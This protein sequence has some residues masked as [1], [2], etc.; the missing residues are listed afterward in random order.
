MSLFSS[1]KGQCDVVEIMLIHFYESESKIRRLKPLQHITSYVTSHM[2]NDLIED[3]LLI[4][5]KY[6]HFD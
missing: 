6:F 1:P 3:F 2:V 4:V 5:C